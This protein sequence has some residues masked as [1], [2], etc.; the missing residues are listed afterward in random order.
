MGNFVKCARFH[1]IEKSDV[2]LLQSHVKA[3]T[4]EDWSGLKI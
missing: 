1:E 2:E 4:N 3:L